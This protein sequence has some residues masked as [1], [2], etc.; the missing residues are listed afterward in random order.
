VKMPLDIKALLR[1]ILHSNLVRIRAFTCLHKAQSTS[2]NVMSKHTLLTTR[3]Y[4]QWS[5]Q[6]FQ[7]KIF[8]SNS[9]V[10]Y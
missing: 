8:Q 3:K 6:N 2:T 5:E 9:N 4:W 1:I 10:K 7:S